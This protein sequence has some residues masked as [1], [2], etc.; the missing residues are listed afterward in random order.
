VAQRSL[1]M[2]DLK[3]L[4]NGCNEPIVPSDFLCSSHYQSYT[5]CIIEEHPYKDTIY[6][7]WHA[8]RKRGKIVKGNPGLIQTQ[9]VPHGIQRTEDIRN[10]LIVVAYRNNPGNNVH[11]FVGTAVDSWIDR[12][13]FEQSQVSGNSQQVNVL[14]S[15][16]TS[17]RLEAF[18]GISSQPAQSSQ[19][20]PPDLYIIPFKDAS[21][22]SISKLKKA[23]EEATEVMVDCEGKDLGP[24]GTLTL[25]Q[26]HFPKPHQTFLLNVFALNLEQDG[27]ISE[28]CKK[29]LRELL[30][31]DRITKVFHDC[32]C[33]C[34]ALRRYLSID[35]IGSIV[36]TQILKRLI[37]DKKG[38]KIK[39]LHRVGFETLW[40]EVTN[41]NSPV[42]KSTMHGNYRTDPDYWCTL[43]LSEEQV[44]Y[45]RHDVEG[46]WRIYQ[47]LN[48][49]A[50][51]EQVD[52]TDLK[53]L[54]QCSSFYY[55]ESVEALSA[56]EQEDASDTS[57]EELK[58]LLAFLPEKISK[59]INRTWKEH[60]AEYTTCDI[61]LQDIRLRRTQLDLHFDKPNTWIIVKAVT[62]A[63]CEEALN[64]FCQKLVKQHEG[65]DIGALE[66]EEEEEESA[67]QPEDI[68]R[69]VGQLNRTGIKG[70]LH[71]IGLICARGE[72]LRGMTIRIGRH[73]PRANQLL[74][75]FHLGVSMLLVGVPGSGKT[76]SVRAI[77]AEQQY[78]YRVVVVD[79]SGEL[80]GF[81]GDHPSA[82]MATCL[83]VGKN[84]K[85][86]D[87]LMQA[88][89]NHNPELAVVDE[90][91]EESEARAIEDFK[92]RSVCVITSVHA[93]RFVD[94]QRNPKLRL[95][96][97]RTETVTY[98]AAE[99]Q[100]KDGNTSG[101]DY[102]KVRLERVSDPV[103]DCVV[104]QRSPNHVVIYDNVKQAAD[105][106]LLDKIG[107]EIPCRH[108]FLEQGQLRKVQY[109]FPHE[110]KIS[111][112]FQ[113]LEQQVKSRET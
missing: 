69:M 94:I 51:K 66:Q 99:L 113:R 31:A 62:K 15:E 75:P 109:D 111:D 26:L 21:E 68:A 43:T 67:V 91:G 87:V 18:T 32:R 90:I 2:N 53:A 79:S 81:D 52:M 83:P 9:F 55:K 8:I 1:R 7:L 4:I 97:G 41:E 49:T 11:T 78:N 86:L 84:D 29:V 35:S 59:E 19:S 47:S 72:D 56:S 50:I 3:C 46:L 76:T 110:G 71:R 64:C 44:Q 30:E 100:K 98:G 73:I 61:Q 112:W 74:P 105:L 13:Q 14:A 28:E 39:Q 24:E 89:S 25:V 33:D 95:L 22:A 88:V 37:E 38:D 70:T 104:E 58:E 93:K 42:S 80:T 48:K 103:F 27:N 10:I 17:L 57:D 85:Q 108:H 20:T 65:Q 82:S 36:D 63:D 12:R 77:I 107:A 16:L 40:M 60:Q 92:Q 96:L 45:A 34:Y 23:V 101:D 6:D 106:L 54:S 102:K 5:L